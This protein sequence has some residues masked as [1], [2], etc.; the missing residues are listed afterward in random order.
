MNQTTEHR[1]DGLEPDNLLAF[2]SLL[3]IV[4]TLE[5]VHARWRPRVRWTVD[6]PPVRP[7]LT[8]SDTITK[9]NMAAAVASGLT[10]LVRRHDFE[11][12]R[13]LK[14]SPEEATNRL[15]DAAQ[16]DRY[17]ADLWAALVS[18]AAVRERNRATEVEPTPLCLLFGQGHQHFL[19]RLSS[20]PQE[21]TPPIRRVNGKKSAITEVEC[22]SEAL[23]AP[24]TRP[25][26]THSFRWDPHED[27]RYAL[28]ATDPTDSK[29]KETTQHGANRLAAVGLSVLTVVPRSRGG[30]GRLDV[31]GGSRDVD[32][33]F[34]F[35]WPIWR[36]SISLS[37]IRSLL[38]YQ[39]L[40][41]VATRAA[42]GI[43]ERRRARRISSGKFMNFTRAES[44]PDE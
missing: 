19:E 9:E 38:A 27:V 12:F 3:G 28:R 11:P 44:M 40:D 26:A 24:W 6:K 31:L 39:G 23:F 5:E 15:A 2:L 43:S 30:V 20:V 14:L 7:V 35:T 8:L 1:L 17:T 18:D 10:E 34:S 4:R 21:A 22:L 36:E 41:D 25:D 32:G 16:A 29:T 13:D 37:T 42:L 33:S